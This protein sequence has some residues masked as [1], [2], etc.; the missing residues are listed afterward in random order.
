MNLVCGLNCPVSP[1]IDECAVG[2]E[3]PSNQQCLNT[4]GSFQCAVICGNG[5]RRSLDGSK[6]EGERKSG[7]WGWGRDEWGGGGAQFC[8]PVD[9]SL[10]GVK[11]MVE[12]M[13]GWVWKEGRYSNT[14]ARMCT[15][16]HTHAHTHT[17]THTQLQPFITSCMIDYNGHSFMQT[18]FTELPSISCPSLC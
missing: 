11:G 1:D 7:C 8:F 16:L 10:R 17:C 18:S 14:R 2:A 5:F 3:C 15:R 13:Y 9:L 6:C 12:G 4:L